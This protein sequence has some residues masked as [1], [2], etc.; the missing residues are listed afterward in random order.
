M[1]CCTSL[2]YAGIL[3]VFGREI[4]G[5]T[6]WIGAPPGT[7]TP[8]PRI[9][10]VSRPRGRAFAQRA[11]RLEVAEP[12]QCVGLLLSALLSAVHTA[13]VPWDTPPDLS[14]ERLGRAT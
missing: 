14:Q 5:L 13:T 4:M 9:K 11:E 6:C 2:L 1:R 12:G 7:R 8:N 10:R 3:A